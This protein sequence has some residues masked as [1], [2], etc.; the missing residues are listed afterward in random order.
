[1]A[2]ASVYGA[3]GWNAVTFDAANLNPNIGAPV[4]IN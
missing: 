4:K 1:M 2:G 3:Y